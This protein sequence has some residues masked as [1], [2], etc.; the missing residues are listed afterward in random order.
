MC[1][2]F[3]IKLAS[4]F[5]AFFVVELVYQVKCSC[6]VDRVLD[7][8]RFFF[9]FFKPLS[10]KHDTSFHIKREWPLRFYREMTI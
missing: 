1:V 9:F 5:A 10:K 8:A 7:H 3:V 4:R 2:Y 6:D